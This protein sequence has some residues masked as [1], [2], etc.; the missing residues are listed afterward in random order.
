MQW[1]ARRAGA[2]C[3]R[4]ADFSLAA[5]NWRRQLLSKD[6]FLV[7]LAKRTGNSWRKVWERSGFLRSAAHRGAS[8]S[9]NDDFFFGKDS[10]RKEK[11]RTLEVFRY[12]ERWRFMDR[13]LPFA[14][15]F[16]ET[17]EAYQAVAE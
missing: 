7:V 3:S 14:I 5:H 10:E 8:T 2:G 12:A 9:S 6:G 1:H 4:E 15:A 17:D 16:G 13:V 11:N